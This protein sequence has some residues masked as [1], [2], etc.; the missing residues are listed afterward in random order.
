[1]AIH[2]RA[3]RPLGG[4]GLTPAWSRFLV[5]PRYAWQSIT[6]SKLL[7]AY[8]MSCLVPPLFA[9]VIIYLYNNPLA[10]ALV[11]LKGD[12]PFQIDG[13]FFYYL[14]VAQG[15]MAFLITA[16]LGPGLVA[17]DLV[18][19]ALPLYLS[20]PF[21]RLEYV[22]GRLG[23]LF[24]LL[25]LIT[26]V[27][28]V[29]L[30]A[31]QAALDDGGWG[32]RN[33]PLLGGI[34]LAAWVWIGVTSLLALALSAWVKWRIVATGLYAA[35]FFLSAGLGA[36]AN[37]VLRTYWGGLV[38]IFYLVS[39]IWRDLL[40][41]PLARSVRRHDIGDPRTLDIPV[42]WCWLALVALGLTCIL[43]LDRR[44]RGR[45]VVRG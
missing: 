13:Q 7:S 21:S 4:A 3:Y 31:L 28:A 1:M 40:D 38:S 42:G 26:W 23:T 24:F 9:A 30:Y 20:R 32:A 2:K 14:L 5:L 10:Q 36:A 39:T 29:L 44:L 16:W 33:L 27:P 8:L 15:S 19:G 12:W 37:E 17:P 35:A 41:V 22:L 34:V 18:N 45:E 25:S 43:L 11:G 6:E